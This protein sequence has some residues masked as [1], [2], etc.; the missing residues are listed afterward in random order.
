M[1]NWK[2]TNSMQTKRLLSDE[3]INN[4]NGR[5]MNVIHFIREF[6][7]EYKI[8]YC[9]DGSFQVSKKLRHSSLHT[10]TIYSIFIVGASTKCYVVGRGDT[11]F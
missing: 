4:F 9:F 8:K 7:Y 2:H 1:H 5:S 3:K 10:R 6:M 11:S